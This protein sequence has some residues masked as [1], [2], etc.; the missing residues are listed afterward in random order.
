MLRAISDNCDEAYDA[1]CEREFDLDEYA[2]NASALTL[3]IIRRLSAKLGLME[4]S[5]YAE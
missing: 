2:R 5:P 3:S 1:F 4:H